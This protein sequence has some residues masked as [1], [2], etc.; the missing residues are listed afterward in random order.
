M[1]D[2]IIYKGYRYKMFSVSLGDHMRL[3]AIE[4]SSPN[5]SAP[6]D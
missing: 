3:T 5:Q 1:W 2:P 4:P 6:Q